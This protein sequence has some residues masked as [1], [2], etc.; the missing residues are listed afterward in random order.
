VRSGVQVWVS[1]LQLE[2]LVSMQSSLLGTVAA[3]WQPAAQMAASPVAGG[4]AEVPPVDATVEAR[5]ATPAGSPGVPPTGPAAVPDS[6]LR[7]KQM[8][9]SCMI[10]IPL[11][12]VLCSVSPCL[13]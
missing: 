2:H 7:K 11:I 8:R 13:K 3:T 6:A 1:P 9:L 4:G 12:D 5:A 10:E